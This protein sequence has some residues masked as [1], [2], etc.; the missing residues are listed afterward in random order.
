[1]TGLAWHGL[2]I[3]FRAAVA[4]STNFARRSGASAPQASR[5]F[6]SLGHSRS[7][8]VASANTTTVARSAERAL[9]TQGVAVGIA[10]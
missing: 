1:M 5:A 9:D 10:A 3:R 6:Q 7:V 4:A 8:C 2:H